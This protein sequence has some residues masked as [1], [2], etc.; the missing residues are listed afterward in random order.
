MQIMQSECLAILYSSVW[1]IVN[2]AIVHQNLAPFSV[3]YDGERHQ[4]QDLLGD[5]M[6][7]RK[8]MQGRRHQKQELLGVLMPSRKLTSEKGI[9]RRAEWQF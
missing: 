5:L 6:L 9:K 8:C 3:M 4:K 2:R 1:T 7:N